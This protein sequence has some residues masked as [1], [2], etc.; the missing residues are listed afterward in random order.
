MS[1]RDTPEDVGDAGDAVQLQLALAH[2]STCGLDQKVVAASGET[3]VKITRYL[4]PSDTWTPVETARA[5]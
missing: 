1:F 2:A 4:P 5:R 3:L